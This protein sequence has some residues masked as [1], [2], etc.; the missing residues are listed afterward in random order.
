MASIPIEKK[1]SRLGISTGDVE[2]SN[3]MGYELSPD[4]LRK[5]GPSVAPKPQY[6]AQPQVPIV[7]KSSNIYLIT[8]ANFNLKRDQITKNSY[9]CSRKRLKERDSN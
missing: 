4:S 5:F 6:K 2:R 8:H 7:P 9:K 3:Q 1:F